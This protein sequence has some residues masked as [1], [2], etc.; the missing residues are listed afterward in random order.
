MKRTIFFIL[1]AVALFFI[2]CSSAEQKPQTTEKKIKT[3]TDSTNDKPDFSGL[4]FASKIDLNCGMPLSYGV[5]DTAIINGK[6][7]GFC[8]KECKDEYVK[9]PAAGIKEK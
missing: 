4:K 5:G 1:I 7:Y 2:A 9:N 6:V 8:S 3:K